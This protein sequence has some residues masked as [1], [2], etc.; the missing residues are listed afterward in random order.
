MR[1]HSE[2]VPTELEYLVMHPQTSLA[3][4]TIRDYVCHIDTIIWVSLHNMCL[5]HPAVDSFLP[6]G[7]AYSLGQCR[8][9]SWIHTSALFQGYL[10]L[11]PCGG[12]WGL[13]SRRWLSRARGRRPGS[14]W[15]CRKPETIFLFQN[16]LH[17]CLFVCL[18]LGLGLFQVISAWWVIIKPDCFSED[19]DSVA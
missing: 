11:L 19:D 8:H 17:N 9:Q 12:W 10:V 3:S 5:S 2:V 15:V 16:R 6:V 14:S 13:I 4:S 18:C 7:S 1:D